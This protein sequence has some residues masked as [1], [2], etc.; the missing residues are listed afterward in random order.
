MKVSK[1]R[2]TRA[3]PKSPRSIESGKASFR[4][5]AKGHIVTIVLLFFCAL[6]QGWVEG[7]TSNIADETWPQHLGL[8]RAPSKWQRWVFG[9]I[10]SITYLAAALHIPLSAYPYTFFRRR[11]IVVILFCV[12][13]LG[14]LAST[15]SHRWKMFMASRLAFG[16]I[17]GV[18]AAIT[19]VVT[20]SMAPT[21]LR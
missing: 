9:L 10:G 20:A 21:R 17:V 2:K 4:D 6:G 14:T 12:Y 7:T 5:Q 13:L 16:I 11:S 8:A 19:L 3:R 18:R 1:K 15:F